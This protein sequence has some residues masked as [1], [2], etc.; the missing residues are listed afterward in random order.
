MSR[1][2]Y[3]IPR[4]FHLEIKTFMADG[5][6]GCPALRE[7]AASVNLSLDIFL[8]CAG[9]LF[10][11]FAKVFGVNAIDRLFLIFSASGLSIN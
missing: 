1:S 9:S 3:L 2:F 8:I 6:L 7:W 10:M 4:F 5:L 11:H